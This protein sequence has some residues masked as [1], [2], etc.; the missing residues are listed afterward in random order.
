M[1]IRSVV[2]RN[3]YRPSSSTLPILVTSFDSTMGNTPSSLTIAATTVG[4]VAAGVAAT[5]V[6]GLV[7]LVLLLRRISRSVGLA[8]P[9]PKQLAEE[10]PSKNCALVRHFPTLENKLA[11]RSLGVQGPSPVHLCHLDEQKFLLKREDLILEDYAGNKVRTLQHQLAV[12]EARRDNG[13][14]AFSELV[15]VGSGGSNQVVATLVHARKVGY[16]TGG[17]HGVG[18]CW[19]DKDEP[20]LDNTL[21]MLSVLSFPKL[22]FVHDWGTGVGIRAT[23]RA[24]YDAWHQTTFVPMMLGG[25][26]ASG[27]LGQAGGLLEL[28]EQIVAKESPDVERIYVPVGSGCTV[29]GLILGTVMVRQLGLNALQSNDFKIVACNVHDKFALGDRFLGLHVNPLFRFMPLTITHSVLGACKALVE[30][31]GPD[32]ESEALEFIKNHVEVRADKDVVGAYGGHSE[33]SRQAANHYDEKGTVTH[34][35]TGTKEKELWVCGH[36][37][38]KAFQPL[39]QDLKKNSKCVDND[40]PKYMLWMTKSAVQPRGNLNEW[41]RLME[42]SDEVREWADR[43]KAESILRPGKVSIKEGKPEDY[44]SLMT[45]IL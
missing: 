24:L 23:I 11:W 3:L 25:N 34:Y 13:E 43:G 5:G 35:K 20:D 45:E 27:V 10:N 16:N 9:N 42:R 28:A 2:E 31:G 41:T 4:A 17:P 6:V 37:V 12:C 39:L 21:N 40:D 14:T 30:L 38:A 44:R 33:L 19:F 1:I 18:A 15:A 8:P 26:C 29:S 22:S 32:L 36:F 7:G